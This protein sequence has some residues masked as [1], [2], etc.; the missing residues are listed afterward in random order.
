MSSSIPYKGSW[1]A[2]ELSTVSHLTPNLLQLDWSLCLGRPGRC[3]VDSEF[4]YYS[5]STA[6]N[7]TKLFQNKED[8]WRGDGLASQT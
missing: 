6:T 7:E 4:T 3:S 2:Q 1:C 5:D 8:K